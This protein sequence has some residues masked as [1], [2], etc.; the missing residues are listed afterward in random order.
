[1][2][3]CVEGGGGGGGGGGGIKTFGVL[4]KDPAYEQIRSNA[5]VYV[6]SICSI[7]SL[8]SVC[9]AVRDLEVYKEIRS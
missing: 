3:V 6:Y 7:R 2:L 4:S 1:M 8:E 9:R 5:Y